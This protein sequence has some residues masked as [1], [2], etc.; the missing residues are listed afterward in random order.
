MCNTELSTFA[1]I[2]QTRS[3]M[4]PCKNQRPSLRLL[5]CFF[6]FLLSP[7]SEHY[8]QCWLLFKPHPN[9]CVY[10][11]ILRNLLHGLQLV[12]FLMQSNH[13]QGT[14]MSSFLT[15]LPF[16]VKEVCFLPDPPPPPPP[17]P[18]PTTRG[19]VVGGVVTQERPVI[20]QVA[21]PRGKNTINAIIKSRNKHPLMPQTALQSNS[22]SD[23]ICEI[24][25]RWMA[26]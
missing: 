19:L 10:L 6:P 2:C 24:M 23:L 17:P 16:K 13:L 18:P 12:H 7:M 22:V 8:P 25:L 5:V 14:T 3:I 11:F 26:S 9:L 20:L 4:E 1:P 21:T 15:L